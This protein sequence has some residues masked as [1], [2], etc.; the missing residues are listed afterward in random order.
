MN[1]L[2]RAWWRMLMDLRPLVRFLAERFPK[3]APWTIRLRSTL[4][5]AIGPGERGGL[6]IVGTPDAPRPARGRA[7]WVSDDDVAV[8][9]AATRHL[10]PSPVAVFGSPESGPTEVAY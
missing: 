3:L 6:W 4:H 2:Y 5:L 7:H 10:T 1:P 8:R 9:V